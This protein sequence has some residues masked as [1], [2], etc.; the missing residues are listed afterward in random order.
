MIT[1]PPPPPPSNLSKCIEVTLA[2]GTV[3]HRVWDHTSGRAGNVFNPGYGDLD[4]TRF[5]PLKRPMG[6]PEGSRVGTL[7][8]GE[9]FAVAVYETLF[10]D[11]PPTPALRQVYGSKVDKNACCTLTVERDLRLASLHHKHLGRWGLSRRTLIECQSKAAYLGTVLWAEAIH[12]QFPDIDGLAW[13]SRQDDSAD[14]YVFFGDRVAMTDLTPGPTTPFLSGAGLTA[15]EDLA[16]Q[17]DVV[18]T[19]P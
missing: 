9:T 10:R 1:T 11:L 16:D 15:I 13:T 4:P 18:I 17:D 19:R 7:Y 2:K 5:A 6:A 14:A 8:A 12:D 3:I